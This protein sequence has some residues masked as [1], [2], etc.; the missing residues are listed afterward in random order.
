M[1]ITKRVLYSIPILILFLSL[2]PLSL[3]FRNRVYAC[4]QVCCN[5]GDA[6]YPEW[7]ASCGS[8]N[9]SYRDTGCECGSHDAGCDCLEIPVPEVGV[10]RN[11][12]QQCCSPTW[13]KP[14]TPPC[15]LCTPTCPSPFR[16]T[17]PVNPPDSPDLYK[18]EKIGSC[19]NTNCAEAKSYKTCYEPMSPQ[20]DPSLNIHPEK[21]KTSL[22]FTSD[23]YTGGG[24]YTE[25]KD[26]TVNDFYA[27]S[28]VR[29]SAKEDLFYITA[30]YTD[31]DNPIEAA[32]IW[33]NQSATKPATPQL[34]DFLNDTTPSS[35]G[36]GT[37]NQFGFMIHRNLANNGEVKPY[38]F[39]QGTWDKPLNSTTRDGITIFS[40]PY[41][42]TSSMANILLYSVVPSNDGKTLTMEFSISFKNDTTGDLLS[43]RPAEG[44]YNIWLMANDTFGF[45]PYNYYKSPPAAAIVVQKVNVRWINDEKIRYYNQWITNGDKWNLNFLSPGINFGTSP[46][47]TT[48]VKLTW[49]YLDNDFS[50]MVLNMYKS[51]DLNIGDIRSDDLGAFS[52]NGGTTYLNSNFELKGDQSAD[53]IGHLN[54]TE[55]NYLFKISGGTGDGSV[56]LDLGNDVG[57]GSLY[58]YVTAF[59]KGGNINAQ[60]QV[61]LDL[62]DWMIT[63]GGLL[64]ANDIK[65]DTD[66][67]IVG[68]WSGINYLNSISKE[69]VDISTELAGIGSNSSVY[70]LKSSSIG[71]YLIKPFEVVNPDDGYYTTY[72]ILFDRRKDSLD[73]QDL[74]NIASLENSL[75][76]DEGKIAVGE[77]QGDLTVDKNFECNGQGI[78][79]V[80]GNLI[81][82]DKISN[83]KENKDACIFIVKGDVTIKD[84]PGDSTFGYDVINMYLLTDGKITIQKATGGTVYDG[85]YISGGVHTLMQEADGTMALEMKRTLQVANRLRYPALVVN[86]HS[87]YG[88]LGGRVFGSESQMQE[89]EVGVTGY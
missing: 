20:P 65:V 28:T 2:I 37:D 71:S 11:G 46:E 89:V 80:A 57:Q 87:K 76:T 66:K 39:A 60:S 85:L 77:S 69:N 21:I 73:I 35:Y 22:G 16:G 61:E 14:D 18:Y 33:F 62:R 56:N 51:P 45:T 32:Y 79:F 30:I 48:K 23:Y 44:Q 15:V 55:S 78:F 12:T 17:P 59:D 70:S 63:Q 75:N 58:F 3:I 4:N 72:K 34:F 64:K 41:D 36:Y 5:D 6:S 24:R 43:N 42:N 9:V 49:D 86:H 88:L 47:G 81:V 29:Y 10:C 8:P 38:V 52:T 1:K 82:D 83:G 31:L 50:D 7:V 40:L 67:E 68:T 25:E 54:A 84:E 27:Y 26:D 74:G 53:T 19:N 13:C